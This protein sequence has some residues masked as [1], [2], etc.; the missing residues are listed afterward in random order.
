MGKDRMREAAIRQVEGVAHELPEAHQDD[1][2]GKKGT[3]TV[4]LVVRLNADED[5]RIARYCADKHLPASTWA[6]SILM[7]AIRKA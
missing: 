1:G 2:D 6:R 5:R 3:R 7:D 4:R